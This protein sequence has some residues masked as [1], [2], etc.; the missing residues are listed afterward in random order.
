MQDN[1]V[2]QSKLIEHIKNTQPEKLKFNPTI[3][4]VKDD[5]IIF[6]M[7]KHMGRLVLSKKELTC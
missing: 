5:E 6:G 3:I 2:W 4:E 7:E 1:E